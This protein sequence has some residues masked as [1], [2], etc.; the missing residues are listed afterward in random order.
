MS[1]AEV[2]PISATVNMTTHIRQSGPRRVNLAFIAALPL[3]KTFTLPGNTVA[4]NR[5]NCRDKRRAGRR[6]SASP[7]VDT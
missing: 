4:S 1:D 5:H 3:T 2:A 7:E 6:R